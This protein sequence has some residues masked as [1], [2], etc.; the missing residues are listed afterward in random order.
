MN[1]PLVGSRAEPTREIGPVG[2]ILA[3]VTDVLAIR[4]KHG[5]S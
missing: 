1:L 3:A 2:A 5:V 4:V